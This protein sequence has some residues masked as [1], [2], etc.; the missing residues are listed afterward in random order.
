MLASTVLPPSNLHFKH[1]F[2]HNILFYSQAQKE[3]S[4]L[5]TTLAES[6][7]TSP[8]WI[9]FLHSQAFQVLRAHQASQRDTGIS[10]NVRISDLCYCKNH[11]CH[12]FKWQADMTPFSRLLFT[13]TKFHFSVEISLPRLIFLG[14]IFPSLVTIVCHLGCRA[15]HNLLEFLF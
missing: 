7:N 5:P 14:N 1:L 12:S 8:F 2:S 3:A 4:P 10:Q 13:A 15:L 6:N 11:Y 9:T